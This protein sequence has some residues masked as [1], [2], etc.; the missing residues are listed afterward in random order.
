MAS[1][2]EIGITE[3]FNTPLTPKEKLILEILEENTFPL[4]ELPGKMYIYADIDN[5]EGGNY[6]L[7][8]KLSPR[9]LSTQALLKL[10]KW[11]VSDC[12]DSRLILELETTQKDGVMK[13]ERGLTATQLFTIKSPANN[14]GYIEGDFIRAM[15]ILLNAKELDGKHTLTHSWN[16]RDK[17][18]LKFAKNEHLVRKGERLY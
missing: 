3:A 10:F 1:S 16:A 18:L 4:H 9:E 12:G 17:Y 11:N 8:L 5:I 15:S 13:T 2:I 14:Y 6:H 7:N